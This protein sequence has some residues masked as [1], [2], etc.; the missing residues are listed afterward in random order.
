M[1]QSGKSMALKFGFCLKRGQITPQ[2]PGM[3]LTDR[4]APTV[5]DSG[6]ISASFDDDLFFLLSAM[7]AG[8]FGKQIGIRNALLGQVWTEF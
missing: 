8:P 3:M 7:V 2:I 6:P 5:N 4:H 1:Q